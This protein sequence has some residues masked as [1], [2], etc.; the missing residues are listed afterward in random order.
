[1]TIIMHTF[2]AISSSVLIAG[3]ARG[4]FILRSLTVG[5][6]GGGGDLICQ[7]GSFPIS[8]FLISHFSFPRS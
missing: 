5:G 1:M 7:Y 2:H 4:D 6:W 8:P 3:V